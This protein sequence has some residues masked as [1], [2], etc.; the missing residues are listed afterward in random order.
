MWGSLMSSHPPDKTG[1]HKSAACGQ[2]NEQSS[3]C[4]SV[5]SRH[6]QKCSM[7][8]RLDEKLFMIV[9]TR[10]A[11]VERPADAWDQ[12]PKTGGKTKAKN[13]LLRMSNVIDSVLVPIK[14]PFYWLCSFLAWHHWLMPRL[15]CHHCAIEYNKWVSPNYTP[16]EWHNLRL[17][18][19]LA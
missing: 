11:A 13:G 2:L 12:R 19:V 3:T 9:R 17:I 1:I 18:R 10:A 14:M 15:S 16:S 4:T 8:G 6:P 5:Q 7:W